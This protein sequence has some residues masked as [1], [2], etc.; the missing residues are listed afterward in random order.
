M[1]NL[2]LTTIVL[3]A[4]ALTFS[5]CSKDDK[6]DPILDNLNGKYEIHID[7]KLYSKGEDVVMPIALKDSDGNYKNF[8]VFSSKD[9]KISISVNQFPKEIGSTIQIE[10]DGDPGLVFI[11]GEAIYTTRE[12][13]LTRQSATKVLFEG[14]VNKAIIGETNKLLTITGFVEAE[15]L[16]KVK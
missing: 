8:L 12:G 14:K 11:D 9:G 6:D 3:M 10:H 2:I 4:V 15:S 16:K 1:K 5:S 7:G 13:T